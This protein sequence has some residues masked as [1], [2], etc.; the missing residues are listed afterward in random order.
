MEEQPKFA[1]RMSDA[2][3]HVMAF[4]WSAGVA[5]VAGYLLH[6]SVPLDLLALSYLLPT[7]ARRRSYRLGLI[8]LL[9]S[10]LV[11]VLDPTLLNQPAAV[12]LPLGVGLR[13]A[14]LPRQATSWTLRVENRI[15]L[16][17]FVLGALLEGALTR[18]SG[19]PLALLAF[20]FVVSAFISLPL[21]QSR[22][23]GSKQAELLRSIGLG[24]LTVAVASAIASAIELAHVLATHIPSA[25]LRGL[26]WLLWPFAYVAS[27][28][29]SRVRETG[30]RL[31]F[32][33]MPR[34][35]H[36][37]AKATHSAAALFVQHLITISF[38]A[39]GV[40]IV[41]GVALLAY[42]RAHVRVDTELSD[43][44]LPVGSIAVVRDLPL[45]NLDLGHGPRR[46][47][48]LAVAHHVRP[49]SLPPGMTARRLAMREAWPEQL[50]RDYERARY[51]L[52]GS[53][54]LDEARAFVGGFAR[55][56]GRRHKH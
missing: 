52:K 50:L 45:Q 55:H 23:S 4:A 32:P 19:W 36:S 6:L 46:M 42:R 10:P 53:F 16:V 30:V 1:A 8:G 44:N 31:R 54:S 25:W 29:I 24:A 12:L 33:G 18:A 43:P 15:G 20:A 38:V 9:L 5:L 26:L 34:P 28:V 14:T 3:L 27:L 37:L 21:A 11:L 56:L 49:R 40:L 51:A 17:A 39:L 7:L 35:H 13:A 22:S 48:R 41:T 2:S 47:V